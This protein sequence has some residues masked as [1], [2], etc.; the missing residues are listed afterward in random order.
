MVDVALNIKTA[1][2]NTSG[3]AVYVLAQTPQG[4]KLSD[5]Q[6]FEVR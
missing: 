3:T 2:T 5:I 6:L 4:L 1:T